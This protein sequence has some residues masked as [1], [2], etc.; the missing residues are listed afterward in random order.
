MMVVEDS[1]RKGDDDKDLG[2]K[3]VDLIIILWYFLNPY[4]GSGLQHLTTQSTRDS[5][6]LSVVRFF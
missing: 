2:P 3:P 1:V 4:T 5:A 6:A